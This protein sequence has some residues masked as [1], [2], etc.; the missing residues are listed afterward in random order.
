MTTLQATYHELANQPEENSFTEAAFDLVDS[1]IV[2]YGEEGLAEKVMQDTPADTPWQHTADILGI[3]IWSTSDNGSGISRETEQWLRDR[4]DE[5]RCWIALH[6]DSSPF[7]NSAEMKRELCEVAHTFPKL[8]SRCE[9][10]INSCERIHESPWEED[11]KR[12]NHQV[13]RI[14]TAHWDD[15][16]HSSFGLPLWLKIFTIVLLGITYGIIPLGSREFTIATL[17]ALVIASISWLLARTNIT[18]VIQAHQFGRVLIRVRKRLCSIEYP[19]GKRRYV[20]RIFL[21]TK[22]TRIFIRFP[23]NLFYYYSSF[24]LG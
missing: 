6:L 16:V 5:R 15:V 7:R 21:C 22:G 10:R 3:M 19:N 12:P 8:A 20:P 14:Y 9:E 13:T 1:L 23:L 2:E 4:S 17:V 11:S 18:S 24:P